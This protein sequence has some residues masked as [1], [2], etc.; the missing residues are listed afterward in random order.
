M[1]E[2]IAL[3]LALIA[4]YVVIKYVRRVYRQQNRSNRVYN[5][6]CACGYQGQAKRLPTRCPR[7]RQLIGVKKA[8]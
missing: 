8:G 7:C 2:L 4:A 3:A 5:V 1:N 6:S